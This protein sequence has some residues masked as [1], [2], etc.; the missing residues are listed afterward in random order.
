MR[1]AELR[2]LLTVLPDDMVVTI[3]GKHIDMVERMFQCAGT[4]LASVPCSCTNC[5]HPHTRYKPVRYDW[6]ERL[7]ITA[8]RTERGDGPA[9]AVYYRG[10]W[11]RAM[12]RV[13]DAMS[14]DPDAR[15]TEGE[16]G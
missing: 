4:E 10:R 11:T 8:S 5:D 7:Q 12:R 3:A 1:V 9:P 15:V 2:A 14:D 6:P 16:E 13:I